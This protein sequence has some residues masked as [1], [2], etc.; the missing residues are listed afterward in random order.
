VPDVEE[1]SEGEPGDFV[2]A[3]AIR[4]A[5]AV[6]GDVVLGA[7]TGVGLAGRSFGKPRDRDEAE[8]FLRR[9]SGCTH[10]VATGLAIVE[11]GATSSAIAWTDVTFRELSDE[12][13]EWYLD[14][15]EWE[16][17]AG[18]Y[19]IQGKGAALVE[20]IDGD[21]LNVVGLP[22]ATLLSL[23]PSLPLRNP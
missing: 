6:A 19:A 23:K 4:K 7:D 13:V 1:L 14:S 5:Q 2:V 12:L 11:R 16:G 22:V 10:A 21:Y 20:R 3:N 17:R 18:G 8:G 9:L 15:G